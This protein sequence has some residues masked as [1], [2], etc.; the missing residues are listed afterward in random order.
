[1][2]ESELPIPLRKIAL[3][4]T[5]EAAGLDD[6]VLHASETR[7]EAID[8]VFL[9]SGTTLPPFIQEGVRAYLGRPGMLEFDPTEVVARGA[10]LAPPE[11]RV[12][13]PG[14]HRTHA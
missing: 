2:S 4:A 1:M 3:L 7:P 13:E 11:T 12:W 10:C 5:V 6:A 14:V 8:S 9:A